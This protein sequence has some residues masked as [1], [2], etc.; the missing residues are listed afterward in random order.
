MNHPSYI[1]FFFLLKQTIYHGTGYIDRLFD[2]HSRG[3]RKLLSSYAMSA[4]HTMACLG[5]K[6]IKRISQMEAKTKL[7]INFYIS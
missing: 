1:A 7:I 6:S 5:R 4:V 2:W 3:D